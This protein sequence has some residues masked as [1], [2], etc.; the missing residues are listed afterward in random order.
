MVRDI[1]ACLPFD[2]VLRKTG[3][4]H[5]ASFVRALIPPLSRAA[6]KPPENYMH[7]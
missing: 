7:D 2:T 6:K 1:A 5:M 3:H 4:K